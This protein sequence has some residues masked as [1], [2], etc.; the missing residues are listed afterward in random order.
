WK[1]AM[2]QYT[3]GHEQRLQQMKHELAEVFPSVVLTGSSYEGISMSRCVEQG[4]QIAEQTL[5]DL[6]QQEPQCI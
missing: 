1:H 6:Q 5:K 4:R 3:V 2:P